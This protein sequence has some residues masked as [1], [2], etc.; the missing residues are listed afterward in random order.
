MISSF[1][2]KLEK[3]GQE[4]MEREVEK[5]RKIQQNLVATCDIKTL[6]VEKE[7]KAEK[8]KYHFS[9]PYNKH[10]VHYIAG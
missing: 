5:L 9:A 4:R 10:G 6:N 8:S 7:T 2:V 1:Q 3:F